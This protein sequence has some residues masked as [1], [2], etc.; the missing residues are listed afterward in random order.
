M[1]K[2]LMEELNDAHEQLGDA[3][4]LICALQMVLLDV[5][6]MQPHDPIGLE[7]RDALVGIGNALENAVKFP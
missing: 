3:H 6:Q 7:R 4:N 2:S 5:T 1:P